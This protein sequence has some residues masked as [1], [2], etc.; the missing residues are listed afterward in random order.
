MSLIESKINEPSEV[1]EARNKILTEFDGIT[2]VEDGHKYFLDGKQLPS[3]S[4]VVGQFSI[5]FD[6]EA[7]A[8]RYASKHGETAEYWKDQW[9]YKA[10]KATTTGTLVHAYGESLGWLRNGHPELITPDNQCKY[11][12]DKNWLIPTRKKEEAILKFYDELHDSLHFVLAETQVYSNKGDASM[13]KRQFCGTFDLL[14][15]Y[16][17]KED[18]SK[19]GLVIMDYKTNASLTN[20]F[21]RSMNKMMLP[22]FEGMYDE[23]LAHYQIQLSLY[24]MCLR[25]IGFDVKGLRLIWLQEDGEY[26]LIPLK[27]LSKEQWFKEAF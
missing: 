8:E 10:L 4:E 12:A 5:P 26:E 24:A 23:S 3:V 18:P 16:D 17:C 25:G 11:I 2:F 19:S 20:D 13:V 9:R 21:A 27:D 22:P 6:T 14:M 15:W 1:I 7:Q